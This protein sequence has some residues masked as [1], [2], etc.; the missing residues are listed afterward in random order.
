M[1]KIRRDYLL[2]GRIMVSRKLS[3][4]LKGNK[5]R[6]I[7]ERPGFPLR[8]ICCCPLA[9]GRSK[10]PKERRKAALSQ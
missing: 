8:G 4:D 9:S 10:L 5:A 6:F 7:Y 3:S 2:K 1:P